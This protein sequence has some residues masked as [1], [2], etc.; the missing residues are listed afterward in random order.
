[1]GS[2]PIAVHIALVAQLPVKEKVSFVR[3]EAGALFHDGFLGE[4]GRPR[5]P[6]TH[7]ITG[8]NPVR[9]RNFFKHPYVSGDEKDSKSFCGKFEPCGVC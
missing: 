9:N 2:T 7:K 4:S 3:I 8:S 5:M 6:V 1:M